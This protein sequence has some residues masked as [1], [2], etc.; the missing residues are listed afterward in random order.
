MGLRD[1]SVERQQLPSHLM[2]QLTHKVKSSNSH[3][4][5]AADFS[6]SIDDKTAHGS[7]IFQK[8]K[9]ENNNSG[10]HEKFEIAFQK[11]ANTNKAIIGTGP[12]LNS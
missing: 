8:I 11:V 1:L 9:N 2:D 3:T 4:N 12:G 6:N 5:L 10:S 7:V